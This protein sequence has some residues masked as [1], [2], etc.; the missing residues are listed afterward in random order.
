MN[1][2][3]QLSLSLSLVTNTKSN[4]LYLKNHCSQ[5]PIFY[6]FLFG[7]QNKEGV[8]LKLNTKKMC[9][10]VFAY[11]LSVGLMG[12]LFYILGVGEVDKL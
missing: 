4:V 10:F 2:N 8:I 5:V 3:I 7:G 6:L 9:A 12:L 11:S 1:N